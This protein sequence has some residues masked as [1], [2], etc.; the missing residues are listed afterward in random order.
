MREALQQIRSE[1]LTALAQAGD[2]KELEAL[3]IRFLGKKGALTSQLARLGSLSPEERPAVGQLANIL[4]QEIDELLK[5]RL[6]ELQRAQLSERL[7]AET[8]DV[9]LPGQAPPLGRVHPMTRV[10]DDVKDIFLGMGFCV[11]EG[12][13]VETAW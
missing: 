12:P 13:E 1:A 9:T 3:R 2:S 5:T 4:R 6:A 7:L 11:V 8:L 10:L